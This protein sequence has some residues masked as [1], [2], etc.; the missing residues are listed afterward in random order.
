MRHLV[1][2]FRALHFPYQYSYRGMIHLF[3]I[4]YFSYIYSFLLIRA[5]SFEHL[6]FARYYAMLINAC[7]RDDWDIVWIFF[8]IVTLAS[9]ND[10]VW[11]IKVA[12]VE[13]PMAGD[14]HAGR[15]VVPFQNFSVLLMPNPDMVMRKTG[16]REVRTGVC[17][18]LEG[19]PGKII[20]SLLGSIWYMFWSQGLETFG[21][22]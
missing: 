7:H 2:M 8:T 12:K 15:I 18:G 1:Y 22:M 13:T 19:E 14:Q 9:L 20:C 5:Q 3:N 4:I 10:L 21:E 17:V 6:P 11:T 16:S